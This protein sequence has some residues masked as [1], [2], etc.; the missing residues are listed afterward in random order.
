MRRLFLV[1]I[2]AQ[3]AHHGVIG[4]WADQFGVDMSAVQADAI[5]EFASRPQYDYV[6]AAYGDLS[7][8]YANIC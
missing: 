5:T 1:P 3:A 2:D 4:C 6:I 8:I 7:I